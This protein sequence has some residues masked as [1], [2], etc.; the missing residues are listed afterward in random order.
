MAPRPRPLFGGPRAL[1]AAIVAAALAVAGCGA[2]SSGSPNPG[3]SAVAPAASPIAT[4][5]PR[6]SFSFDLP[7]GWQAVAVRGNN[8]ALLADLRR[9]NPAFAD[10]LAARLG[11]LTGS[12]TYV[13]FDASPG[14]VA[15]GDP[16]ILIVTEVALPPDVTLEALATRIKGLVEQ[17]IE[18]HLDLRPLVVT[19]GQATSIAYVGPHLRPDGQP[20]TEAVTQVFYVMPGRGYAMTFA[21]PPGQADAYAKSI[22]DIAGSFTI[23]N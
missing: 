2:P 10:A 4:P 21:V 12:S 6:G 19:A 5:L 16:A 9:Q 20:G 14:A 3:A 1:A 18:R 7:A 15:K 11:D 22:A 8:D 23:R 13:A 17:L